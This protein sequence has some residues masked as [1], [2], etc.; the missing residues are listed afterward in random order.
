MNLN[1]TKALVQSI[2]EKDEMA[3]NS[4]YILYL[5]VLQTI[6]N[7]RNDAVLLSTIDK[8]LEML[9]KAN[10]PYPGFET[11]RRSRQ[12]VQAECPWLCGC[13]KV[14]AFREENENVFREFARG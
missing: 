7:S 11:V 5:R 13:E 6:S 1:N 4:D 14:E 2:L 10:C 8:F 3:R 9:T 12:K